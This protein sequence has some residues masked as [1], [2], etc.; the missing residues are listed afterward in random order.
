[1]N[2]FGT[3]LLFFG[4]F[5]AMVYVATGRLSTWS[6]ARDV[7]RRRLVANR[8]RRRSATAS[9]SGST[10]GP[11]RRQRLPDRAVD[12]HD[13]RRRRL[14]PG[15]RQ[16]LHADERGRPV[17]P[18]MQTD[19][20]YSA[21][22]AELG[23]AGAAGLLLLYVL[24]AQRGLK[25]ATLAGDGFSKLLAAGLTIVALQ[26]FIIVGGV[27]RADPADGHHAAVRV[28][29]RLV[30]RLELAPARAAVRRLRPRAARRRRREPR[31]RTASSARSPSASRCSSRSPPTGRSGPRRRSAARQDNL[32]EVVQQLTIE[33]GLILA[34]DG[35]RLALNRERKTRDGRTRLQ[36]RYPRARCS[37]TSSASR[38]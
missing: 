32:H 37:R 27:M 34:A 1:M 14:R 19:F 35:T 36:R 16:G 21:I 26:A 22:A 9:R 4:V 31:D 33:R 18:A 12:L 7:R 11:T 28:L 38:R 13:R 17:I 10:R 6:A 25:T 2:D 5:L 15:A 20:I 29:R 8:S 3:S 24:F 23:L 30:D